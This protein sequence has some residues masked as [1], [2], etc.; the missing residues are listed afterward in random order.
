M[1]KYILGFV[2]LSILT[3]CASQGVNRADQNEIVQEFYASVESVKQ[4]ELSSE[5]KTGIVGGA[6]VGTIDELDGNSEDMISGAIAGALVGGI[7]TAIFEGSN[8]AY[9]YQLKSKQKGNFALIQKEQ[10][11]EN[12]GCVKVRVASKVQLSSTDAV[13]CDNLLL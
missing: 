6:V 7:F 1:N 9:E 2:S 5:V 10:L 11:A 12:A 4:V 13:N 3:G 8:D